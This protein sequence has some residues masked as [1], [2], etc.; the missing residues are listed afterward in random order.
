MACKNNLT[1][2]NCLISHDVSSSPPGLR[3]DFEAT[4]KNHSKPHDV[5]RLQLLQSGFFVSQA[6]I[7]SLLIAAMGGYVIPFLT[8]GNR[9]L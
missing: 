8:K 4:G 9:S 2:G 1:C 3:S 6:I 7:P 5:P